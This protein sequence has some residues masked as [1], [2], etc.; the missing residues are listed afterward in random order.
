MDTKKSHVEK[1]NW[2]R[3][4]ESTSGVSLDSVIRDVTSH[5]EFYSFA[6][7]L[8]LSNI[9][10]LKGQTTY[11]IL[12]AFAYSDWKTVKQDQQIFNA[13]DTKQLRKLKQLTVLGICSRERTVPLSLLRQEIEAKDDEEVEEVLLECIQNGTISGKINQ[14]ERN[15]KVVKTVSRDANPEE[16]SQLLPQLEEILSTTRSVEKKIQDKIEA[17]NKNRTEHISNQK[18]VYE[19]RKAT[20]R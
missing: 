20:D 14:K 16:I 8:E 17:L 6:E 4:A 7:F 15:F 10:D 13:L 3:T 2:I 18:V 5:T 11:K 12:E 1:K 9:R 19:V